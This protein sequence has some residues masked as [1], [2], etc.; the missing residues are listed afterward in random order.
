ML[1]LG[2]TGDRQPC[3]SYSGLIDPAARERGI[4]DADQT[5]PE[6]FRQGTLTA[7]LNRN[8][9]A[10]PIDHWSVQYPQLTR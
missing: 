9:T 8:A 10:L 2:N 6:G 7:D 3:H 1:S 5:G 4:G